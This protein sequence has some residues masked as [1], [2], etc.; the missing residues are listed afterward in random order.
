MTETLAQK[1]GGGTATALLRLAGAA[2]LAAIA[3][4]HLYLWQDGYDSIDV[5]GPAFLLQAVVGFA[6]ALLLVVA[7]PR[8]LPAAAVLGA[9]FA[10]GSLAAILLSSVELF[11]RAPGLFDFVESPAAD[12]WGETVVVEV[13]AL[14]VLTVLAVLTLSRR[15]A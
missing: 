10:A 3:G 8:I 9:L 5:I 1:R 12:L 15:R 6:G 13:A 14:V 2:L 11:G 4:I 7:P